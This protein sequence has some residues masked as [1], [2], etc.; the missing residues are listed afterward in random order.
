MANNGL[1]LIQ[2][3]GLIG[4]AEVCLNSSLLCIPSWAPPHNQMTPN[5]I[6]APQRINGSQNQPCILISVWMSWVSHHGQCLT[7]GTPFSGQSKCKFSAIKAQGSLLNNCLLLFTRTHWSRVVS[8]DDFFSV[9]RGL[10]SM[11]LKN[12][13]LCPSTE[14]KRQDLILYQCLWTIP[15]VSIVSDLHLSDGESMDG[16]RH[17]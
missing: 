3:L 16:H 17:V 2:D 9:G 5:V 7:G 11:V 13:G 8:L 1:N 14:V 15:V 10:C 12:W 4:R 6:K